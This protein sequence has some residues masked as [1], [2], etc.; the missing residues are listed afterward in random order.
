MPRQWE[1]TSELL[2]GAR[3]V[4]IETLRGKII[5]IRLEEPPGIAPDLMQECPGK[6]AGRVHVIEAEA[7]GIV[8]NRI[9]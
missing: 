1:T 8:A 9:D 2:T 3:L 5:Q 4:T 6:Y 7:Y